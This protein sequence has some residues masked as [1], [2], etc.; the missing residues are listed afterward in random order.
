VEGNLNAEKSKYTKVIKNNA[1]LGNA[2]DLDCEDT[3]NVNKVVLK[4]DVSDTYVNDNSN[5][6]KNFSELKGLKKYV[7]FKYFEDSNMLLP[8]ETEYNESENIVYTETDELGTY[9]ENVC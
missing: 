3:C 6:F 9:A 8:I 7:I 1:I 5:T 4:F 2:F